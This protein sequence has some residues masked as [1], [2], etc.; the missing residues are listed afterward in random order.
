MGG[1]GTD[2][3]SYYS[4]F[5]SEFISAAINKYIYI[6][7][8]RSGF[9]DRIRL[10]YSRMEEVNNVD[11]IQ[12]EIIRETFKLNDVG[13]RVELTSHAEIPSGT[14]LGSSGSFGVGIL[15]ALHPG[16]SKQELA[17]QSTHIQMNVLNH[18][19]GVQDQ[20]AAAYGGLNIYKVSK[21]GKVSTK[22]F[23]AG[24]KTAEILYK[25]EQ[26]LVLFFTG[27][28]REA[29]EILITQREKAEDKDMVKSLHQTQKLCYDIKDALQ[30][31]NLRKMGEVMNKHWK[32]KKQ[33]SRSMTN[34]QIDEWYELG[35]KN[36][37]YGGKLVGAGAG[38]FLLFCTEERERLI[39]AMPLQHLDFNFDFVGSKVLIQ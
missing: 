1:G 6:T 11:E 26:G 29:N 28:K 16:M 8:H 4:K 31:G 27:F 35:L 20:Y 17:E 34:P 39:N 5:G 23:K 30:K 25:L 3:P 7:C 2:L 9:D 33:R 13:S 36:G 14:G 12:N 21:N 32:Y 22:P 15:Q 24:E 38:G 19:I 10:R 37:A 18:P